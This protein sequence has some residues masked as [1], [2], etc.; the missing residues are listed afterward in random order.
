M[1]PTCAKIHGSVVIFVPGTS[2][3]CL[4]RIVCTTG[5]FQRLMQLPSLSVG[6]S[7]TSDIPESRTVWTSSVMSLVVSQKKGFKGKESKIHRL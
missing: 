2:Y 1:R 3:F 7:Q 5:S 6:S 4:F